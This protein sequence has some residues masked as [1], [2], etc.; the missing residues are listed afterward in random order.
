MNNVT[1]DFTKFNTRTIP[2][3]EEVSGTYAE[4]IERL[5]QQVKPQTETRQKV[6]IL[7]AGPAGLIRA[8]TSIM[9]GNPTHIIEK[10]A[11]NAPK[12]DNTVGLEPGTVDELKKLGVYQYLVENK[13]IFP[14][15]AK[16]SDDKQYTITSGI[17]VRL[18]DLE[19][20][21]K[22]VLKEIR[23]EQEI[24]YQSTVAEINDEHP[25]LS[26]TIE[27]TENQ[28]SV[29]DNIGILVN[30]EGS[31]STT[32]RLLEIGRT[33]VLATRPAIAAIFKDRRPKITSAGSFFRY[34]GLSIA[35]LAKTIHYHTLFIFKFIFCASF[36]RECLG[37]LIKTPGQ[38]YMGCGFSNRVNARIGALRKVISEK[39]QAFE[40]A[41]TPKEKKLA[42]REL[43]KA[44]KKYHSY[45]E[46]RANLGLCA[47]NFINLF[48]AP[49]GNKTTS[50]HLSFVKCEAIDIGADKAQKFALQRNES[51]ILL[52]G[53]AAATVDPSSG[54]GCNTALITNHDFVKFIREKDHGEAKSLE[55]K[56][57]DYERR[58]SNRVDY[59]HQRS[60]EV[61]HIFEFL[62]AK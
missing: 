36:R 7:G 15:K 13:L 39:K 58:L 30:T 50:Q 62:I 18:G 2:L 20:A 55:E 54:L 59:I 14:E 19:E 42:D 31:R 27:S 53:D 1:N 8:I 5:K 3:H 47:V 51:A 32:N 60:V 25:K 17:S 45:L 21:L 9:N 49:K 38:T 10:R 37:V 24:V 46:D 11:E 12:R 28:R 33:S 35:Y 22:T 44:E 41:T 57:S 26:L 61:R 52:A 16:L 29:I 23:P 48:K 40:A 43:K 6:V 56:V 34:I 4:R